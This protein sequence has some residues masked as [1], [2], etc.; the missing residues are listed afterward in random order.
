MLRQPRGRESSDAQ[1][2]LRANRL[3]RS[4]E[5]VGRPRLDLAE[6]DGAI[7]WLPQN[8]VEF[9]GATIAPVP[10]EDDVAPLGIP[11]A[12]GVF[13]FC[14][15]HLRRSFHGPNVRP[16]CDAF[17]R[18]SAEQRPQHESDTEDDGDRDVPIVEGRSAVFPCGVKTHCAS[19]VR[20]VL[21]R[22]VLHR[23]SP[24]FLALII[25]AA[26]LSGCAG[27]A[28]A[29][30]LGA[31]GLP[32]PELVVG[33]TVFQGRCATCHGSTGSGG[34]GKKLSDG[35]VV[36]R[37]PDDAVQNSIIT[38]GLGGRMPAFREVLTTEE[39]EAVVRYTR[40]VL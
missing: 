3:G 30:P 22:S 40:E 8:H 14:A 13:P 34:T 33:Q 2:F 36:A 29:L 16:D 35:E 23:L 11:A 12:C 17:G 18:D 21:N 37:Y 24:M 9:A 28:P 6:D 1:L 19:I 25:G 20:R 39:I 38:N 32:D 27:G 10:V 4:T 5:S 31:D 26:L 15:Q 7:D